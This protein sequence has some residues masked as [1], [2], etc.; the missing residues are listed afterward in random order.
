MEALHALER[1]GGAREPLALFSLGLAEADQLLE[2][3]L[4][5][6]HG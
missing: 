4:L 2:A 6:A 1:L 5:D 3:W